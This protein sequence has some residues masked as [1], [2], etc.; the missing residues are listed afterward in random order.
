MYTLIL[1]TIPPQPLELHNNGQ[2][3][4]T[5]VTAAVEYTVHASHIP[6]S[7]RKETKKDAL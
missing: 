2:R 4:R 7:L 1:L 5:L 3:R 6:T